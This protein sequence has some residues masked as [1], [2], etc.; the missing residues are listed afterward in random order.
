MFLITNR[1]LCAIGFNYV[2]QRMCNITSWCLG[3]R[4]LCL[5]EHCQDDGLPEGLLPRD[6][7][8]ADAW[9]KKQEGGEYYDQA[10]AASAGYR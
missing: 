7:E 6:L 8:A 5:G 1:T 2:H 3:D 4:L 9:K 10:V